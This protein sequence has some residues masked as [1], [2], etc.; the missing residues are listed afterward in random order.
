MKCHGPVWW[1]HDRC[2]QNC[3]CSRT[4]VL[5][6]FGFRILSTC[7]IWGSQGALVHVGLYLSIF[8]V[9]E[10]KTKFKFVKEK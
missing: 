8:T 2:N 6:V 4:V 7:K 5:K 3:V 1:Y 10:V 9:L